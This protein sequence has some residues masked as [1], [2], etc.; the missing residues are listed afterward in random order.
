M[1]LNADL[2]AHGPSSCCLFRAMDSGDEPLLIDH[3]CGCALAVCAPW[4]MCSAA[5]TANNNQTTN[6]T[7]QHRGLSLQPV[8]TGAAGQRAQS[9]QHERGHRCLCEYLAGGVC[10]SVWECDT[11]CGSAATMAVI[12]LCHITLAPSNPLHTLCNPWE[13]SPLLCTHTDSRG[14]A[15]SGWLQ[16]AA[17][18]HQGAHL[19]C[20]M[21]LPG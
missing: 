14:F 9:S 18:Y 1:L 7:P 5:T 3:R 17:A 12:A 20:W 15:T 10:C 8:C 21:G 4:R 13:H 11:G 16:Q 2:N 6:Y 19:L